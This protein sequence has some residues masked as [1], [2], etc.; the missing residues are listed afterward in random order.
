MIPGR[1]LHRLA[2]RVCCSATLERIVEPA[3]ADLQKEYAEAATRGTAERV[4]TLVRGYLAIL[5]VIVMCGFG[6][7]VATDD[8][9]HVIVRTVAWAF[10]LTVLFAVFLMLPPMIIVDGSF[11]DVFLV[12]LVPQAVPLAIPLGFTFGIAI[13][14][15]R[16]TP[17]GAVMR[18]I[19]ACAVLGSLLSFATMG[20]I[21]PGANQAWRE[22]VARTRGISGALTK[23][24]AEMTFSELERHAA[25]AV[26]A[27][28]ARTAG[29]YAWSF[30]IRFA[31]AAAS[32]VLTGLLFATAMRKAMA[33]ALVALL[34]CFSY[35]ALLYV[36]QGLAGTIPAV[37]GAWL[38]NVVLAAVALFIASSRS[39]R[40]RVQGD[41][42]H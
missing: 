17:T 2:A 41:V 7:S 37:A 6:V 20:W 33:R 1:R 15:A 9:R 35:W 4:W 11:S 32:I 42:A 31:L 13:G 19:L 14:M 26:A 38:P 23:G 8:D 12:G 22:S 28:D 24:A 36:G 16:R 40:L 39:S 21:L 34:A 5:E 27:G 25:I 18:A 3:I 10:A 29:N 30:H